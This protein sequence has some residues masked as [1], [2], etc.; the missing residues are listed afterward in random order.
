[1]ENM[2]VYEFDGTL[3]ETVGEFLDA[4]AHEYKTGDKDLVM[5]ALDDYGFSLED[6][7]VNP[8]SSS[9]L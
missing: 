3:Y 2:G 5:S 9:T 1:M 4:L 6:I 8:H 7:G